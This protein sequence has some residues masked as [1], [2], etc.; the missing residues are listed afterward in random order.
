MPAEIDGFEFRCRETRI[1]PRRISSDE[2]QMHGDAE[3][4]HSAP[5]GHN[6]H[7]LSP[8]PKLSESPV[9]FNPAVK[10]HSSRD[11]MDAEQVASWS[12]VLMY[13]YHF[14]CTMGRHDH[15]MA[16]HIISVRI[17]CKSIFDGQNTYRKSR[18]LCAFCS[19]VSLL[20]VWTIPTPPLPS[21]RLS[22][23]MD[24]SNVPSCT[25]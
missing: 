18:S 1:L 23:R 4:R 16:M 5:W 25:A 24:C 19:W 21:M 20:H 13:M 22:I 7:C 17:C 9:V 2:R 15:G 10:P 12:G 3:V 8:P 6:G 11:L 14:D